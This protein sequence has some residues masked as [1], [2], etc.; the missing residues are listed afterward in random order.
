MGYDHDTITS[1][2]SDYHQEKLV[3]DL[4]KSAYLREVAR[5]TGFDYWDISIGRVSPDQ[6]IDR[7][8]KLLAAALE[9]K[10]GE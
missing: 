5:V 2:S 9:P 3:R 1:L 6:I 8:M 4:E 10:G 7:L